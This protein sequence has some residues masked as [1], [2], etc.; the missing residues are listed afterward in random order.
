[1]GANW[2]RSPHVVRPPH[3]VALGKVRLGHGAGSRIKM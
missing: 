2:I 1:M 3:G